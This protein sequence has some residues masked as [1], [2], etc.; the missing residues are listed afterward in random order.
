MLPGKERKL[1][2]GATQI[3]IWEAKFECYKNFSLNEVAALEKVI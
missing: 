3:A 2:K 1:I